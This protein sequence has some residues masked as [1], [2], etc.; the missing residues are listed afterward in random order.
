MRTKTKAVAFMLEIDTRHFNFQCFGRTKKE[1]Y[2][3]FWECWKERGETK[4]FYSGE[5]MFPTRASLEKGAYADDFIVT[6]IKSLPL[7]LKDGD[8]VRPRRTKRT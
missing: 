5:E 7:F 8:V 4:E 1:C 2:D 3:Y 6:E